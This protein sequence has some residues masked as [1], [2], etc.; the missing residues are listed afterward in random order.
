MKISQFKPYIL[1]CLLTV[2]LCGAYSLQDG[3]ASTLIG[4]LLAALLG[5]V[6]YREHYGLCIVHGVLFLGILTLFSGALPALSSGIPLV[7]L[8]LALAM[9]TRKKMNIYLMLLL[10]GF[11]FMADFM[12]GTVLMEQMSG[13]E[14]TFSGMMLETGNHLQEIL[15][16]QYPEPEMGAVL[17]KTVNAVIDMTVMLAP[18]IFLVLSTV[19]AYLLLVIYKKMQLKNGIDMAFLLPFDK[20]QGQWFPAVLFLLLFFISTAAPMGMFYALSANVLLVLSFLFVA[21]GASVF[22]YKLQQR[23]M[24]TFTRRLLIFVLICFSSTL[25]MIPLFAFLICGLADSFWDFRH[26]RKKEEQ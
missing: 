8:G 25:F 15:A 10:C 24:R 9:G 3:L 22:D 23:G 12:T 14:V 16:A 2:A 17:Q 18:A 20:L 4:L 19:L 21:L 1:N 5:V 6:F 13:G 7:L 26:L 11:L